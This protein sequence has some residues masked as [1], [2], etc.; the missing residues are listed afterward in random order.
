MASKKFSQDGQLGIEAIGLDTPKMKRG[1]GFRAFNNIPLE[2]NLSTTNGFYTVSG[3]TRLELPACTR[4]TCESHRIKSFY[5]RQNNR[6]DSHPLGRSLLFNL[7]RMDYNEDSLPKS[8]NE[9]K[10]C[11]CLKEEEEK[12]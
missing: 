9:S 7:F 4:S 1:Q 6:I 2:E 3:N 11:S 8:P 12:R 10:E 5:R